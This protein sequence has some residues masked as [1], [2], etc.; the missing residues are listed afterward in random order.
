MNVEE[1]V[2]SKADRT[3]TAFDRLRGRVVSGWRWRS[4]LR[5]RGNV[6]TEQCFLENWWS[7][8]ARLFTRPHAMCLLSVW[9]A[10]IYNKSTHTGPEDIIG[11]AL[12]AIHNNFNVIFCDLFTSYQAC[13]RFDAGHSNTCSSMRSVALH[14]TDRYFRLRKCFPLAARHP[15]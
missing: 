10:R 15:V 5:K 4:S 11:R 9:K 1:R 3:E 7:P 12:L 2:G 13:L 8:V 14:S 6:D